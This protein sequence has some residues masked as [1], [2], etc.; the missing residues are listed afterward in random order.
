[1]FALAMGLAAVA[2]LATSAPA[3]A[4]PAKVRRA[5]HG[6]EAPSRELAQNDT[7]ALP[8][9]ARLY[10]FHQRVSGLDVLGSD[11]VVGDGPESPPALL[12]ERTR[13]DI[14]SPPE[15]QVTSVMARRTA[16]RAAGVRRLDGRPAV[17]LAI[18]PGDGGTLVWR[19]LVPSARPLGAFEVLVDARS[20]TV[21]RARNLI[22]NFKMGHARLYNP[23]PVVE[24]ARSGSL[25]GL[26]SDHMDRDTP[27]LTRLRRRVTL[28]N[29]HR[30]QRCLRGRWAHAR[31][32][33]G[34]GHEV[35]QR[36]LRWGR[37][38]RHQ[39]RFEALMAYY[40]IN[41]AQR[42]IHDLGFARTSGNGINDQSQMVIADAHIP[43]PLGQD[44]SFYNPFTRKIK[45][46]AGG[47][48]DAED[49]D[50]ILHEYGHAMQFSQSR[51][52]LESSGEDALA[53]QEGSADYWAAAMSSLSP[54]TAN[55]DDV[56]IFDW[57]SVSYGH[58]FPP[59]APYTVARHCG[60]RID[61]GQGFTIQD[62]RSTCPLDPTGQPDVHCVGE[63]WAS[64]LWAIRRALGGTLTDQLY[65]SAQFLYHSNEHFSGSDGA[66]AALLDAD[67]LLNGG[68]AVH[69]TT[70]CSELTPRGIS[71]PDC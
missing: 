12:T 34:S 11:A 51:Q 19:V 35:C 64:A 59:V 17:R 14:E 21:V 31:L 4:A 3:P 62:A 70:I 15:P 53:L 18:E 36:H 67:A 44:N 45:Y 24:R 9:G 1:M 13:P 32:G 69:Q 30:G 60:R 48:D 16:T 66:G 10:R 23:N 40:H 46:G 29:I 63:V 65:L 20:G 7:V 55:E 5:L 39:D 27:L 56:C 25:R 58:L 49:A 68:V 42:Y 26:Q 43:P 57:D 2:L 22:R 71:V 52:F 37:V 8:G 33:R 54:R 61:R 41:R 28:P 6:A 38:T 47:V 50:V